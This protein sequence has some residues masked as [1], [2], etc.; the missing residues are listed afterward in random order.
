LTFLAIIISITIF[1]IMFAKARLLNEHA[2]HAQAQPQG[3][4]TVGHILALNLILSIL[5]LPVSQL[6]LTEG[7]GDN[8]KINLTPKVSDLSCFELT[9]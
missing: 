1:I 9:R 8:A 3:M 7:S 6:D 5:L 2:L 4:S